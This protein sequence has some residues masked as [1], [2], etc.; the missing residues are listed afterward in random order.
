MVSFLFLAVSHDLRDLSSLIRDWTQVPAVKALS[1]SHWTV[2]E[3][4]VSSFLKMREIGPG[5]PRTKARTWFVL[6]AAS[7][8]RIPQESHRPPPWP[9]DLH[10]FSSLTQCKPWQGLTL[11]FWVRI[12]LD[13]YALWIW[14]KASGGWNGWGQPAPTSPWVEAGKVPGSSASLASGE[15]R[16]T[17]LS[18]RNILSQEYLSRDCVSAFGRFLL[19]AVNLVQIFFKLF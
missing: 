6:P 11:W 10:F 3:F 16:L 9:R 14:N 5:K 4:P 12:L 15:E 7:L 2:R 19:V 18:G 17:S 8:S 13:L 1:P